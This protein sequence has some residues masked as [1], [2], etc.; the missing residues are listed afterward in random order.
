M[1]FLKDQLVFSKRLS[2]EKRV[3]A[4]RPLRVLNNPS[5][6]QWCQDQDGGAVSSKPSVHYTSDKKVYR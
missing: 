5:K 1:Y 4:G 6:K 2:E 3:E